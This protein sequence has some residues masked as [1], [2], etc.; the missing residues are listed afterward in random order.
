M[1]KRGSSTK[2]ALWLHF[3]FAAKVNAV[4][5]KLILGPSVLF[6]TNAPDLMCAAGTIVTAL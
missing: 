5:Q 1:A 6:V 4:D 2:K 3:R